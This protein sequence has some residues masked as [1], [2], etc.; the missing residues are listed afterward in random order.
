V[1]GILIRSAL[2]KELTKG[3]KKGK[4]V[5]PSDALRKRC[6]SLLSCTNVATGFCDASVESPQPRNLSFMRILILEC[7]ILTV[8]SSG[9]VAD[10]LEEAT[11]IQDRERIVCS[12]LDQ[13]R[14]AIDALSRQDLCVASVSQMLPECILPAF[15]L[16]NMC[17]EVFDLFGWGKRKSKKCAE[18]LAA[19]AKS[20]CCVVGDMISC[21]NWCV[22]A[23]STWRESICRIGDLTAIL[24]L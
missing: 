13:I 4:A 2:V 17:S 12:H 14:Q 3:P 20:L 1:Q 22:F 18:G 8:L 5:P 15:T 24:R 7:Q 9:L 19:T 23:V 11:G 21:L 10:S 6:K 16:F